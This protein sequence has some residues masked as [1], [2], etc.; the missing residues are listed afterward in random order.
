MLMWGENTASRESQEIGSCLKRYCE[1]L[2]RVSQ[3]IAYS[4][5]CGVQTRNKNLL[6]FCMYIVKTNTIE[7]IDHKFLESG[8]TYM[9]CDQDFGLIEKRKRVVNNV[10]VLEDWM[11]I[12]KATSKNFNVIPMNHEDFFSVQ[13]MDK[14]TKMTITKDEDGN[15]LSW[16]NI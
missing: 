9:E 12:V 15:T 1:G 2:H 10:F 8:H 5:C 16:H 14:F 11:D 3:I 6:K 7:V 4:D 13:L